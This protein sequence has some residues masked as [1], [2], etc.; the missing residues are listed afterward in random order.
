MRIPSGPNHE[1]T[2][3]EK[4]L[5]LSVINLH[6]DPPDE[7]AKG[8]PRR[9]RSLI[10]WMEPP[11]AA[12]MLAGNRGDVP[13]TAEMHHRIQQ[14]HDAVQ[15]RAEGID[16]TDLVSQL[17]TTLEAHAA[18]LRAGPGQQFFNEGWQL[19]LV[20]LPRV[21][22]A[23]PSVFVDADVPTDL[24]TSSLGDLA[25][26]TLPLNSQQQFNV[27]PDQT[28]SIWLITSLNPNLRVM[29]HIA[30]TPAPG[31]PP[32][33]GF[34][35]APC[36]SMMQVVRTRGR[37]V[38]R[39]GYHRAVSLLRQ[40]VSSVP[41]FVWDNDVIEQVLSPG[42]L[43]QSAYLSPRPPTIAD[44]LDDDVAEEVQLPAMQKVI[45]V[46]ATEFQIGAGLNRP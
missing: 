27:L 25:N 44:Y 39:D 29:G 13:I 4:G 2:R 32:C 42:M 15:R 31:Q 37:Y 45:I 6:P 23:Q 1:P 9:A 16:Q 11:T 17:P 34:A 8:S 5:N 26:I 28:R 43:P 12:L 18:A 22:A 7:L 21:C 19:G 46:Q 36:L 38:L 35:V 33:F 41:A 40:G 14:A 20:D 10:G 30:T 24:P 3:R